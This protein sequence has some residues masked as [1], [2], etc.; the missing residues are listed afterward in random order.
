MDSKTA[1]TSDMIAIR[2]GMTGRLGWFFFVP[3]VKPLCPFVFLLYAEKK[4]HTGPQRFHKGH[5]ENALQD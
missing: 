5:K 4:E 2:F 1:S 3:F